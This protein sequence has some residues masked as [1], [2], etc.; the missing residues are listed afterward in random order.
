[1]ID[2]LTIRV[3]DYESAKAFYLAALS[4][5]GYEPV[6]EFSGGWGRIGGFGAGGKA[7]LWLRQ[8]DQPT[9]PE[10]HVAF[11]AQRRE[12]VR[13]F[14]EAAIAGGAADNGAPGPRKD[15]HPDYYGAFVTTADG[16]NLEVCCHHPE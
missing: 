11:R 14:Y 1:M 8:A 5:L 2:H 9:G 3:R 16:V 7:D 12:Q 6:M 15:Y 10:F 4:P 13:A